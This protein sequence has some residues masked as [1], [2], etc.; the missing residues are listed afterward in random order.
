[1]KRYA[2]DFSQFEVD[3]DDKKVPYPLKENLYVI[4]RI[5][6]LFDNINDVSEAAKLAAAIRSTD[7]DSFQVDEREYGLLTLAL[8]RQLHFA[9]Q[10]QSAFGDPI[11]LNMMIR[12]ADAKRLDIPT[13]DED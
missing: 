10:G 12:I 4:L 3:Q 6:A 1:M 7:K 13:D 5:P 11:H 8:N 9:K 2:I